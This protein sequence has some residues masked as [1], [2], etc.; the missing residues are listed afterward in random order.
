MKV[1]RSLRS[2]KKKPGAQVVRRRGKV[3]VINKRDP[4]NKA[5]QA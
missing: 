5:R 3:Y 4:R 1:R 2:L